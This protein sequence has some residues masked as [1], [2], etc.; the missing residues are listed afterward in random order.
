MGSK[1]SAASVGN[2]HCG[3]G[4]GSETL[5]WQ[6]AYFAVVCLPVHRRS[7]REQRARHFCSDFVCVSF[8]RCLTF[9][10]LV[11]KCFVYRC[12]GVCDVLR[13]IN[14]QMLVMRC[15]NK[16][17][18]RCAQAAL[19]FVSSHFWQHWFYRHYHYVNILLYVEIVVYGA[20]PPRSVCWHH[21]LYAASQ[22]FDH[23]VLVV[24]STNIDQILKFFYCDAVQKFEVK[25]SLNIPPDLKQ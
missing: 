15:C 20:N 19:G 13:W 25:Q 3:I 6:S 8:V 9:Y 2:F 11:V 24:F 4:R 12:Q 1:A 14:K 18:Y 17:L 16:V 23:R 10:L 21:R 22:K 5:F 7:R